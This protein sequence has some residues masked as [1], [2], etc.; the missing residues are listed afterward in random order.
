MGQA[1]CQYG[2]GPELKGIVLKCAGLRLT[3]LLLCC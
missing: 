1:G 3:N 2:V